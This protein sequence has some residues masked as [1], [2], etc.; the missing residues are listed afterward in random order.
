MYADDLI[1]RE[2]LNIQI[3]G[4]RKEIEHLE[5]ELKPERD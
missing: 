4:A 5:N 2:E 1:S 3:G